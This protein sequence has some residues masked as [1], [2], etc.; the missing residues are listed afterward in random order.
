[1]CSHALLDRDAHSVRKGDGRL[2]SS[3][4][5]G[6]TGVQPTVLI[7]H[8]VSFFPIAWP[9]IY[10][11]DPSCLFQFLHEMIIKILT[12]KENKRAE[13]TIDCAAARHFQPCTNRD[14][15]GITRFATIGPRISRKFYSRT[16]TNL[17]TSAHSKRSIVCAHVR[18]HPRRQPPAVV[19]HPTLDDQRPSRHPPPHAPSPPQSRAPPRAPP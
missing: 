10:D 1:M 12:D 18:P 15:V 13:I 3:Y 9:V 11:L 6:P 4:P 14:T 16:L 2:I 7:R 8:H 5:I 17:P 19:Q